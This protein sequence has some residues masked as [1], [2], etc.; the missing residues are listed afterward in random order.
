MFRR[1][2]TS[3]G[4]TGVASVGREIPWIDVDSRP[5][6]TSWVVAELPRILTKLQTEHGTSALIDSVKIGADTLAAKTAIAVGIPF[7]AYIP[8]P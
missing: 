6:Q 1:Q 5:Q 7:W 8:L 2:S 4:A 3:P